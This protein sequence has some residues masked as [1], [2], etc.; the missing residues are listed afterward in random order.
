[1]APPKTALRL[2]AER[3]CKQYPEASNLSLAKR[4]AKEYTTSIENARSNV[5]MIRGNMGKDK[6][7]MATAP[8]PNGKAGQKPKMPPSLAEPWTPFVVEGCK[9]V[10]VISD[11]HIPYHHEKALEAAIEYHKKQSIDTLIINGDFADFYRISRWQQ[12]PRKRRFSEER[13]LIIDGLDWVRDCFPKA[14]IIWKDGNHE[15]RFAHF[16]WNKAPEL[17]D[18]PGCQLP[19]LLEFERNRVEYITDQRPIM[20]GKLPLLHGHE[21]GRSGISS[22]VNPSRGVFLRTMHTVMVGHGHRTSTHVEK[23]MFDREVAVWSTGCLCADN[24]EYQRI[25][26]SNKGFAFVEVATDGTFNVNNL[27]VENSGTVRTA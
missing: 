8:K 27:R 22:P 5:R 10:G 3:L 1:M 26:K 21:M 6:R 17:Y 7:H 16:I 11:V 2:E 4:L 13:K 25:G 9:K 18:L 14:R 19:D 15:E 24:P 12:D 20:V 23:D